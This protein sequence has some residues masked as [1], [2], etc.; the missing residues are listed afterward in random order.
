MSP[1][2]GKLF[3]KEESG[4]FIM[5]NPNNFVEV[6]EKTSLEEK[7]VVSKEERIKL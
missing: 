3:K 1:K 4:L 7:R 2:I 6:G 5:A